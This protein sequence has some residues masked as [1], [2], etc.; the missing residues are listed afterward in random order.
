MK[1]R[2]TIEQL[3]ELTEEQKQRLREWWKP[4]KYDVAIDFKYDNYEF[5]VEQ[6]FDDKLI[7]FVDYGW[8][9]PDSKKDDCLPLLSIGQMI[10]LLSEKSISRLSYI[11]Q[12]LAYNIE[13]EEVQSDICTE[14]WQAVKQVL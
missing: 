6:V 2:I 14:L 9:I 10:E 13:D 8:E 1:R 4:N 7:D 11:F 12:C 5:P 3:Q